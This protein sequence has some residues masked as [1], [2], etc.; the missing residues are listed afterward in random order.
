[1]CD[2]E[3]TDRD[4]RDGVSDAEVIER[5]LGEPERFAEL[6]DRHHRAIFGYLARR[7]GAVDAE[8]LTSE[9]FMRAFDGRGRFDVTYESARPWLFGI[10]RNVYMNEQRRRRAPPAVPID[11]D[12]VVAP[13][14]ADSVAWAT[15]SESQLR[16]PTLVAAIESLHPDIRETLLMFAVDEMTYSEIAATLDVPLGTVRSRLGRARAAVREQADPFPRT[17][18]EE[19]GE[20]G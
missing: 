1:M 3:V 4:R 18:D 20:Y 7:I 10:A 11:D 17:L 14:H 6:F 5:S 2:A 9:V 8:D 16:D 19:G 12:H 15:D 13:D